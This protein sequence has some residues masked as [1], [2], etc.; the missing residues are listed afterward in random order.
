MPAIGDRSAWV[1]EVLLIADGSHDAL[2]ALY[3]GTSSRIYGLALY[4]TRNSADAA[5]ITSEVYVQVWRSAGTYDAARAGVLS[6]LVAICHSRAIDK[7]RGRERAK[8]AADPH[9]LARQEDFSVPGADS[10]AQ[11]NERKCQVRDALNRL[12][13]MQRQ[14]IALAYYRGLS[15]QEI[16][17]QSGMPLGTVKS[18]VRRALK[19]LKFSMESSPHP[20]PEL[21]ASP[22]PV[23]PIHILHP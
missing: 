8:S 19:T 23:M 7:I 16:A 10:I 20:W 6:W 13:P 17:S 11:Q 21:T 12:A 2:V 15:H 9:A 14:M 4:V 22:P 5:E 3:S 18:H 1:R